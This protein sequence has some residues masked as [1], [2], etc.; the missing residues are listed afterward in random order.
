MQIKCRAG[1]GLVAATLGAPILWGTTY[2]VVT[3]L[4]PSGHP[5]LIAAGRVLPAGLALVVLGR[6]LGGPAETWRPRGRAWL[7]TAAVAAPNFAVFFP[8][9][10]LA[11]QRLPGAWRRRSAVSSR[12]WWRVWAGCCWV[13]GRAPS[14]SSWAWSP[15][16][17]SR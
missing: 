16:S 1:L 3:G 17:G 13:A 11:T 4:L 14:S 6:L 2:I 5:L 7:A 8:L 9:L 10:V 15:S 12:S